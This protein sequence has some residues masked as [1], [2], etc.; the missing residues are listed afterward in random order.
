MK[1]KFEVVTELTKA[2]DDRR[3]L[4]QCVNELMEMQGFTKQ[5]YERVAACLKKL[6]IAKYKEPCETK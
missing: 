5:M 1:T 2:N 4:L 3:E 6:H